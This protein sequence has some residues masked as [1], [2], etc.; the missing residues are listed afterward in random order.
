MDEIQNRHGQSPTLGEGV[1]PTVLLGNY[2]L[3]ALDPNF[4]HS[5]TH[6]T[7]MSVQFINCFIT[8]GKTSTK[9][10]V[11]M[12]DLA[13]WQLIWNLFPLNSY[14]HSLTPLALRLAPVTADSHRSPLLFY[15]Q[16]SAVFNYLKGTSQL[17]WWNNSLHNFG[18]R[19]ERL[20]QWLS[21]D[22]YKER[23]KVPSYGCQR[24]SHQSPGRQI[25]Y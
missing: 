13:E 11:Q 5:R 15:R 12:R 25:W 16:S 10:T 7:K 14:C 6:R 17:Y 23:K 18:S 3:V 8:K 22:N 19:I 9:H 20:F 4:I 21:H 24:W 2:R 1:F